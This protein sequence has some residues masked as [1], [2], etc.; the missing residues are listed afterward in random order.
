MA[1]IE[2]PAESLPLNPR[3]RYEHSDVRSRTVVG[4][5][6]GILI[7]TWFCMFLLYFLFAAWM[8]YRAIAGPPKPARAP[9]VA[10]E[11]PAP[12]IQASPAA[13]L[14]DLR[15]YE[16]SELHGYGWVDK[17]KGIVRIPIERAIELVARQ[18]IP[19]KRAPKDLKLYPPQAG[20]RE[21]GFEGKVEPE[22]R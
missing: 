22:P 20:T 9:Q 2:P 1:R 10:V 16:D 14:R 13:D 21:T 8:H 18:G 3:V 5:G 6:A 12:R 17:Q 11:P 7:G 15:A 19:P 4:I